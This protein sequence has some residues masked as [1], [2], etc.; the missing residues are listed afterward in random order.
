MK[1]KFIEVQNF[2][3][4]RSTHIDFDQE[5]T[6]FVGANNSGKTS[7]ML[8]LRYFLT[9][10]NKLSLR[11]ITVANWTKIDA[12]G[13]AWEQN[14]GSSDS[15]EL[16]LPALDVWLDVPLSEIHH[17]VH[18]LPT[19]DWSGGLLGVRLLYEPK[20]L[21]KLRA[22]YIVERTAARE[23]V[24][25]GVGEEGS[26]TP[27]LWP[28]SL[29]DFLEK[30]L[31]KYLDVQAYALDP[32]KL[33][34]PEKGAAKPQAVS[35]DAVP[36]DRNPFKPLV[37]I[38]EIAAQRDFADAGDRGTEASSD[39]SSGSG[40]RRFKRKL[41]DQLRSYYDRHLDPTKT[42]S[43]EDYEALGAIQLAERNF[44]MRLKTH[45]APAFGELEDLGYPGVSNPKLRINTQLRATDGLKHGS[46]VQYEV[47]DPQGDGS[48]SLQLPEDYSGLGYQ[49]L[50][51]MVFMLMSYRDEWMRVGKAALFAGSADDDRIQPLHLVLVEEPEAH[52]HAQ[53]QQVFIKKAYKLLRKHEDLGDKPTFSTQLVVSTHSGHV[54]HEA[55]FSNLRYFRRRRA[56]S[57]GETPT[58]TVSNLSYVFGEGDKTQRFVKRYLKATH[59][60]LFFA[61]GVIFVE[62]QAER[63]LVPH[64]IRHHF[65]ELSRR[66]VT[67]LDLG[68]SHAHSFKRLVDELGLTTLIIADLDATIA[69]KVTTKRGVET[70]RWKAAK[71][72]TGKGQKT[73]NPVLKE[74]HPSKESIDEL[75]ALKRDEHVA[76]IEDDYDLYVAFQK[77][78]S[79]P[80]DG[81]GTEAFIART[82][83]DALVIANQQ[84]LATVSGSA[85]TEKIKAVVGS[86]LT[87]EDLSD[88]LFDLLRGAEKAAFALDCLMIEN[89]KSLAAPPYIHD[90]LSWLER[91]LNEKSMDAPTQAIAP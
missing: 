41:S 69:V 32:V 54:A 13:L 7:A 10:P 56:A 57:P 61:D 63:I 83:E 37:K 70:T 45:F 8:A 19:I 75:L 4:L 68:G 35:N 59:C 1:I 78:V 72:E 22:D 5:T 43:V 79:I 24:A 31:S 6:L 28:T 82:F 39:D 12:I 14:E 11:D 20:A 89:P 77:E 27:H 73:S 44:D 81:G 87:G 47:A 62:G 48:R 42:P 16:L 38:D 49:N 36:L 52:L 80:K 86:G 85:T 53:V 25:A 88:E 26:E 67:L 29:T 34:E 90:G 9:S 2:R 50:I 58:T 91:A 76:P 33:V 51:S 23:A 18:I 15:I 71:P 17:V 30:R 55:D 46:A 60:D 40:A 74:W 64:F 66:Y 3:K 84:T 65:D 21:E